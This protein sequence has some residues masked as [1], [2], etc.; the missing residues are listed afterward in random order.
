MNTKILRETQKL[1]LF[2]SLIHFL[3]ADLLLSEE[4]IDSHKNGILTKDMGSLALFNSQYVFPLR[5]YEDELLG[6]FAEIHLQ[7]V[8]LYNA[9]FTTQSLK[10][11]KTMIQILL[12]SYF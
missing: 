6:H 8:K 1:I 9:I 3:N 2:F 4:S 7:F 11:V 10:K 5:L 12:C